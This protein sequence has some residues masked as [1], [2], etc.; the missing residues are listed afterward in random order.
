M[1]E[2]SSGSPGKGR[3]YRKA[4]KKGAKKGVLRTPFLGAG[5][6]VNRRASGTRPIGKN[7]GKKAL[8]MSRAA[9]KGGIKGRGGKK[10]K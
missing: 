7:V 3:A 5:T 1:A 8:A 10:K 6:T 9:G 2:S 4:P